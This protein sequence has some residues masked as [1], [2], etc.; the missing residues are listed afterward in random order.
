MEP[1]DTTVS[2]TLRG[3]PY[4][5]HVIQRSEVGRIL[6]TQYHQDGFVYSVRYRLLEV[7]GHPVATDDMRTLI[8]EV[9][10]GDWPVVEWDSEIG[11]PGKIQ[12]VRMIGG[13]IDGETRE[14][15]SSVYSMVIR[16]D[17]CEQGLRLATY[18]R[19]DNTDVFALERI[20]DVK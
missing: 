13:P 5:G 14:T 10:P 4:D 8:Y 1:C 11:E 15:R 17:T 16:D 18:V 19:V 9:I 12:T 20:V 3:G 6:V 2:L 7:A